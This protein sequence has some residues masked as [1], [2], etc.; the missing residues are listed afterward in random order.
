MVTLENNYWFQGHLDINDNCNFRNLHYK[1]DSKHFDRKYK[2]YFEQA[3]YN[4]NQHNWVDNAIAAFPI[5]QIKWSINC[6][7]PNS[8]VKFQWPDIT[9]NQ[10][11]IK[12]I[13]FL[14]DWQSG[15]YMEFSQR[16]MVKWAAGDFVAF[17][18]ATGCH[19]NMGNTIRYTLE[20]TGSL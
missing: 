4:K 14:E 1:L 9:D 16:P 11:R 2:L 20:I 15:Q 3:R 12:I 10:D 7:Y 18:H 6:L 19:V 17:T 5:S 13:V 8:L